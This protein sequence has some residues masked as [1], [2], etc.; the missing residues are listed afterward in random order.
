MTHDPATPISVEQMAHAFEDDEAHEVDLSIYAVEDW[1]VLALF[2]G[3]ALCVFLQFF[4]RYALN[5]SLAWT[6]EIA[7]NLLVVIVFVGAA[8]CVRLGRHIAVDLLYR[9]LSRPVGRVL[10][11]I[12]DLI[13]IVFFAYMSWL[14]WRY[15]GIV[16][17]ERMVTVD[18]PRGLV[19][20]SVLA[21]FVLMTLRALQNFARDLRSRRTVREQAEDLGPTG[22]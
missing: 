7:A 20:Y 21:G 3:M 18:L 15:V 4:T 9:F 17:S 12:V 16:G 11:V 10:Q 22:V 13:S 6:E 5:N 14:L 1:L 2:W 19:F 8:M